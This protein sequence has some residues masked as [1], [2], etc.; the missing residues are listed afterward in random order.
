MIP[1]D[2]YRLWR[3]GWHDAASALVLCCLAGAGTGTFAQSSKAASTANPQSPDVL[4]GDIST[5]IQSGGNLYALEVPGPNEGSIDPAFNTCLGIK[6]VASGSVEIERKIEFKG[7]SYQLLLTGKTIAPQ[8]WGHG[9]EYSAES[10]TVRG[11]ISG[12]RV[13]AT[14]IKC[15]NP[16]SSSQQT[17]QRAVI[18]SGE[19]AALL[20][21]KTPPLYPPIARAARVSGTV[22]LQAVISPTGSVENL[23]VVSGEPMLQ[24]AALEAVK[25][26]KYKPY[27]VKGKPVEVETTVN[28]IFTLGG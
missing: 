13:M 20:L 18:P 12:N 11:S 23:R 3:I 8:G 26:W 19:A 6:A 28:I 7:R 16:A 5:F 9:C 15:L 17:P 4:K 24:Q 1:F 21:I 14:V 10:C 25:S 2:S 27:L 22:V